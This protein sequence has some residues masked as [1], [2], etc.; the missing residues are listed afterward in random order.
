VTTQPNREEPGAVPQATTNQDIFSLL[1]SDAV[2]CD[3]Y[4]TYA[5]FRAD[6]PVL[7][8]G[9]GVWFAFQHE[10]CNRIL[11][12]R[13]LSVDERKA[14][15][16][17]PGDD[18]P[19]LIHLDPPDHERLR[20]LVQTAFTPTRVEG[21]RGRVEELVVACLDQWSEGDEVDVIAELAYPVPLTV[22]CE[23]L[24]IEPER[25]DRVR[26]WS[27]WLARSID[28]GAL[29]SKELNDQI[30]IVQAEFVDEIRSLIAIRRVT[31]GDDLFS[32]LVIAGDDG[33]RLSELELLG[34]AVLLLV[35]GHETTVSLI[36]NSLYA[37][38]HRPD[39]LAAVRN[40]HADARL[41][42]D[43]M[44]RF[45]SPVQMTTRI[46][47]QPIE[48]GGFTIPIGN[49]IVLMLGAANR[50]PAAFENPDL[51]DVSRRSSTSHLSFGAGIHHCLGM[52]LARAEGEVAVSALIRR[53]PNMAL[54]EEP[55]LRPTFVLR[56]RESL[57]VRL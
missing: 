57:R 45:D 2:R 13:N 21:L 25:R 55:P 28:P 43:E 39:Q 1:N 8:T 31:P 11:R 53:F 10:D 3:P 14:F 51:L 17:G 12:D 23:L 44:L 27:T 48:L 30:A 50:D 52:A 26:D 4:P 9:V 40:G 49:I 56:G 35:A 6:H 24:G 7:D 18:L 42:I 34:L 38:L 19:T 5:R 47:T 36:G 54:V 16:P 37:L 20:R 46:A 32:Q 22:I 41:M 29:R 15:I 33:D